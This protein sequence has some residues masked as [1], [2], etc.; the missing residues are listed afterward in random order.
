MKERARHDEAVVD[1]QVRPVLDLIS[2]ISAG[3]RD[4][5]H[6]RT[7]KKAAAEARAESGRSIRSGQDLGASRSSMDAGLTGGMT[8]LLGGDDRGRR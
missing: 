8:L 4:L 6:P 5:V 2:A 3:V 7:R 1:R